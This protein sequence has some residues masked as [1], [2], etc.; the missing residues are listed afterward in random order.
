MSFKS[1]YKES[2]CCVIPLKLDDVF[3]SGFT[4]KTDTAE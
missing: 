2:T 4:P 3:Y 1:A